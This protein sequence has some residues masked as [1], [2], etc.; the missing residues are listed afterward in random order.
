VGLARLH[1]FRVGLGYVLD[2]APIAWLPWLVFA[3]LSGVALFARFIPEAE[4]LPHAH[5]HVSIWSLIK[6]PQILVL[7]SACF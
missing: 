5:D 3:M 6:S 7:I 4:L 1:R 2:F